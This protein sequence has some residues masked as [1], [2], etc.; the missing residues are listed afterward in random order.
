[1]VKFGEPVLHDPS[2]FLPPL[3]QP[4]PWNEV[5]FSW[6]AQQA[7]R[8]PHVLTGCC[9]K[10]PSKGSFFCSSLEG[11]TVVIYQADLHYTSHLSF[12]TVKKDIYH[13]TLLWLQREVD[14]ILLTF[15]CSSHILF[16]GKQFTI[17]VGCKVVCLFSLKYTAEQNSTLLLSLQLILSWHLLFFFEVVTY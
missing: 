12:L 2:Q 16:W 10:L 14:N 11:E 5:P 13:Q 4:E 15:N 9:C 7:S 8:R 6:A 17:V 1:M 3:T